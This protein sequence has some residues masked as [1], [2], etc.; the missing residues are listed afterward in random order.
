MKATIF[1]IQKNSF[2]DGPGI[3]T[4]VF[5]KGCNLDC[6]WCHN[7]EGKSP[8]KQI[9]FYK[10]RCTRCGRCKNVKLYDENFVCLNDAKRICGREYSTRELFDIIASDK[11]FYDTSN[12]G[13][14]FSG[15]ECMLQID[16]L[17]EILAMCRSAGM[18]TAVDTAG[19]VE[20]ERFE[21][22]M[23]HTDL[24]LY[25]IKAYDDNI[26][27][28]YVG[29][30]N[31]LILENLRK[32]FDNGMNVI[33]RIPVVPRVNDTRKEMQKIKNFLSSFSPKDVQLLP[34]HRM[35]ENKYKAL[36]MNVP[37]FEVPSKDKI[38]ELSKIFEKDGCDYGVADR[39]SKR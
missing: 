6:K 2:V 32:L 22:I 18:H 35:G 38:R 17:Q 28:K 14:T 30:S 10:E 11:I 37:D 5:F 29:V 34:Y 13:V 4:T 24:F 31:K 27:K 8:D 39:K 36:G 25:D 16:F 9:M 33:I 7:P 21:R 23:L 1:D 19:C 26:H 12:G 20:W 15:G 3:R